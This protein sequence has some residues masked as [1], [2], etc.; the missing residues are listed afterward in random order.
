[1]KYLNEKKDERAVKKNTSSNK[2]RNNHGLFVFQSAT[3]ET[4]EAIEPKAPKIVPNGSNL[5]LSLWG[6]MSNDRVPWV[7]IL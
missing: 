3:K 5:N 4:K 1:V 7:S 2:P 6:A